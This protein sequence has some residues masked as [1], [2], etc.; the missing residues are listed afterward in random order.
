MKSIRL[1]TYIIIAV[2]A[3]GLNIS[4]S[5]SAT[6]YV[7]RVNGRPI[8]LEEY[9][10]AIREQFE[11]YRLNTGM[12]PDNTVL[13]ELMDKAWD[14][15][16]DGVVFQQNLQK[17]EISVTYEE[18]IDHL[19]DNIPEMVRSSR[20][21]RDDYDRFDIESYHSSL[22]DNEPVNLSWLVRRYYE[23]ELPRKKLQD[24]LFSR[25]DI[26]ERDIRQRYTILNGSADASIIGFPS[27][28]FS[29]VTVHDVEIRSYY[30]NNRS[31]YLYE[32]YATLNY[33]VLPLKPSSL[34]S[35]RTKTVI[36]SIYAELQQG[37][38]FRLMANV[39]SDGPT[40][41][42]GGELPFFEY[43][44]L[45]Q[46]V[47]IAV[48]SM[49]AG[50]FTRPFSTSDG[51]VIYQVE[52]KTRNMVKLREIFIAHKAS[53]RTRTHRYND[54]I[55]V[56]NLALEIGLETTAQEIDKKLYVAENLTP[57]NTTIPLLGKSDSLVERAINSREGAIFEPLFREDLYAYLIIEVKESQARGFKPLNDVSDEIRNK[58]K[59]RKQREL[60]QSTALQFYNDYSFRNIVSQA[61]QQNFRLFD[62]DNFNINSSI[63]DEKDIEKLAEK[64]LSPARNRLV[65]EPVQLDNG[66]YIGVVRTFK[67]PDMSNYENQRRIIRDML[68][69][70]E[71]K[72]YYEVWFKEQIDSARVRDWRE[73]ALNF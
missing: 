5:K 50:N 57:E 2:I 14:N 36:D 23:V 13:Q 67:S 8:K 18:V 55:N 27:E 42:R 35:L 71:K 51:W 25:I 28:A 65:T 10:L 45:P 22:T 16:I 31:D 44:E 41:N 56:R 47:R 54:V 40:A 33:I 3:C 66:S 21:F 61:R 19:K 32:P 70:E 38:D 7:G 15:I 37:I 60:A 6:S 29:D 69:E 26:P 11:I 20:Q 1:K 30:E 49:S 59:K 9:T 73:R 34:D 62:F 12:R 72:T 58:I 39:E 68:L 64:M 43:S 46:N 17:Y 63:A 24:K 53:E 48:E 4:C 52:N